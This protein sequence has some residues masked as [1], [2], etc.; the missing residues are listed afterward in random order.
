MHDRRRSLGPR[1]ELSGNKTHSQVAD[2]EL[3]HAL[4]EQV[5]CLLVR[6]VTD[7]RHEDLRAEVHRTV[8]AMSNG[9][10]RRKGVA[11]R[12]PSLACTRFIRAKRP[13]TPAL[14]EGADHHRVVCG[15]S[16]QRTGLGPTRDSVTAT[17]AAVA[18]LLLLPQMAAMILRCVSAPVAVSASASAIAMA[19]APATVR[20]C[21]YVRLHLHPCLLCC[22]S[23][24]LTACLATVDRRRTHDLT[25]PLNLQRT[26]DSIPRGR[27]QLS[28]KNQRTSRP[29]YKPADSSVRADAARVCCAR[30]GREP[31]V[32]TAARAV[33]GRAT[34]G[35]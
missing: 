20:R 14:C 35:I 3:V 2:G 33:A 31:P 28:C 1:E 30:L 13:R 10:S 18:L 15:R 24:T 16:E 6:T 34:P 29:C 11:N 22:A 26:T 5:L 8:E 32:C 12:P 4:R 21:A 9:R 25:S 23:A 17:T 7:V 19:I 27:R